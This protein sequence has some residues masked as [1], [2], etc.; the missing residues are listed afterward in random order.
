MANWV[1]LVGHALQTYSFNVGGLVWGPQEVAL[2]FRTQS[3]FAESQNGRQD[4]GIVL[5]RVK[6][7][8]IPNR[9]GLIIPPLIQ[10]GWWLL[11]SLFP[12]GLIKL[13]KFRA[14]KFCPFRR[15]FSDPGPGS[16][17]T[18]APRNQ[19]RPP[20]NY[21]VNQRTLPGVVNRVDY[22]IQVE[23]SST[24]FLAVKPAWPY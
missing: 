10:L 1:R 5:D 9:F 6:V 21:V 12:A 8:P 7:E 14:P 13:L 17:S 4:L 19:P 16:P 15:F 23:K 20:Y 22:P 2:T 11:V 18:N 24:K 3:L